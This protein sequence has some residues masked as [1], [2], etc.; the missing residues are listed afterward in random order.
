MVTCYTLVKVQPSK[1]FQIRDKVKSFSQVKEVITTYGEYDMILKIEVEN[2][3]AL[4][5]FIFTK[6]RAVEGIESTT[7]LIN[8]I[9]PITQDK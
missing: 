7:T 1:D 2:L 9:V 8:A 6:L 5:N 4:D 3:D